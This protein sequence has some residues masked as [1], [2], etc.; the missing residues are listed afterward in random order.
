MRLA[1]ASECK[2][3]RYARRRDAHRGAEAKGSPVDPVCLVQLS[4]GP[5]GWAS[6]AGLGSPPGPLLDCPLSEA[7]TGVGTWS[8]EGWR[9]ARTE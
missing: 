1:S 6:T 2:R 4:L 7:Q 8:L 3:A 5:G 9:D